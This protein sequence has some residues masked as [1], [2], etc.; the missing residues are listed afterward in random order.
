[1]KGPHLPGVWDDL[2]GREENPE[3]P[4]VPELDGVHAGDARHAWG[5]VQ[6]GSSCQIH[7]AGDAAGGRGEGL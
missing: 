2:G 4:G 6:R 1:M 3:V 5:P 7:W